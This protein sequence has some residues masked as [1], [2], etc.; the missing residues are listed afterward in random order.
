M[1]YEHEH[2]RFHCI[3]AIV[4]VCHFVRFLMA[5]FC[6]EIKESLTYLLKYSMPQNEN[7]TDCI[8]R[9]GARSPLRLTV[10]GM[11]GTNVLRLTLLD[12]SSSW[13]DRVAWAGMNPG[14]GSMAPDCSPSPW[15]EHLQVAT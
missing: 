11:L 3:V 4:T 12:C 2:K 14:R 10:G 1:L 7:V 9:L 8:T 6:Q 5:F 15:A 13:R